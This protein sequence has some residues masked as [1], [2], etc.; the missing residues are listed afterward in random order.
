MSSFEPI[1]R[2]ASRLLKRVTRAALFRLNIEIWKRAGIPPVTRS[3]FCPSPVRRNCTG[4][5]KKRAHA[6]FVSRSSTSLT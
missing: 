5:L 3:Q 1:S 2:R 6:R 4:W